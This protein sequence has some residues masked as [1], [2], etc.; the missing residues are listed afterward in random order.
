MIQKIQDLISFLAANGSLKRAATG[1]STA[2]AIP[3]VAWAN[4]HFNVGLDDATVIAVIT[5]MLTIA[6]LYIQQSLNN[7]KHE[8]ETDAKVEI[9]MVQAQAPVQP[10]IV[11]SV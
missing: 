2:I 3:L 10:R 11:A 1:I 9:A 6:G 8:R 5:G 7:A 4:K